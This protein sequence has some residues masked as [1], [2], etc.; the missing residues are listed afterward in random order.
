VAALLAGEGC[1]SA[2]RLALIAAP[3]TELSSGRVESMLVEAGR[4][5]AS[6]P[7][8]GS[9]RFIASAYSLTLFFSRRE[10]PTFMRALLTA[11]LEGR[12]VESAFESATSFS[13]Q[14]ADIDR[15]WRVWLAAFAYGPGRPNSL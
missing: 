13:P 12:T 4:R 8:E 1:D 15:Q 7:F 14:L 6:I 3:G 9:P 10:G 5:N 2:C 11:P